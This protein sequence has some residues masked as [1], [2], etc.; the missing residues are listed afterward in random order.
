MF[1]NINVDKMSINSSQI[2]DDKYDIFPLPVFP[3]VR[4][5]SERKESYSARSTKHPK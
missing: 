2:I 1:V 4:I 5:Y 3:C